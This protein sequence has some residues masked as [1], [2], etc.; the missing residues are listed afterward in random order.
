MN[1]NLTNLKDLEYICQLAAGYFGPPYG[2]PK[3]TK[4][5]TRIGRYR[6]IIQREIY[7]LEAEA[8]RRP[9]EDLIFEATLR[10]DPGRT[11]RETGIFVRAVSVNG[12]FHS[13]DISELTKESLFTWLRSRGGDNL[14]AENTVALLL[15][16]EVDEQ[17]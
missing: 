5:L 15:G 13:A 10:I 6:Q 11:S 3:G 1:L 17:G 14:W 7:R 12:T 2:T 16:Y 8:S 9:G 4:W